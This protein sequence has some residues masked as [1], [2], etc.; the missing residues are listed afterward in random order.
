MGAFPPQSELLAGTGNLVF[1]RDA[2]FF[3][4]ALRIMKGKCNV[5]E[6]GIE[7]FSDT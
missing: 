2:A 5:G 1:I 7:H 6:K 4:F 3:H